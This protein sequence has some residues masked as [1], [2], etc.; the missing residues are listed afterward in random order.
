MIFFCV[1]PQLALWATVWPLLRSYENRN[2][3]QPFQGRWFVWLIP[4]VALCESRNPGLS[5]AIPSGLKNCTVVRRSKISR[6]FL[7]RAGRGEGAVGGGGDDLDFV[8]AVAERGEEV[9]VGYGA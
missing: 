6:G 5:D 2:G 3:L 9:G 4:R 8:G 1:Y 7:M